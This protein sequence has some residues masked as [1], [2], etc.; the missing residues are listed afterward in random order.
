MG[1]W[2]FDLDG[3]RPC[4]DFANTLSAT[5]GEHLSSY[6]D[7]VAFADQSGLLTQADADRLRTEGEHDPSGAAKVLER[8]HRLRA[9]M[10]AMFSAIA[11]GEATRE[12]DLEVLN[13][14]LAESLCHARLISTVDD[15]GFTW[16][17]ADCDLNAPLWGVLR[18]AAEVLTS[19]EDRRRVREC[20]GDE[21]NW[22]FVD[23]SKNR[24][25]QW[26]SMQS[27]GNRHK[28]RRHYQKLRSERQAVSEAG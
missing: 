15:G 27:C 28:A 18:S 21:C 8:A 20:G 25:R 14:E 13:A 12:A 7:L 24:S 9:A 6:A 1:D 26:C 4:L 23:T 2:L 5:S 10:Y 19:E 16:G 11:A 3:G 22:L 17:W